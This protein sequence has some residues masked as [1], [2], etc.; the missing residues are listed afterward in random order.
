MGI[1]RALRERR[2]WG[3]LGG[4]IVVS[5]GVSVPLLLRNRSRDASG[6]IPPHGSCRLACGD[7]VDSSCV[8]Y[9]SC[10]RPG[11]IGSPPGSS[12]RAVEPPRVANVLASALCND[13]RFVNQERPRALTCE[14]MVWGGGF[15]ATRRLSCGVAFP[16]LFRNECPGKGR[17]CPRLMSHGREQQKRPSLHPL[18][19][20]QNRQSD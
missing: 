13:R 1:A 19:S 16:D 9:R 15:R 11:G 14:P 2:G 10:R 4:A 5:E 7:Y 12:G 17:G 3:L 18:A 20:T 8:F 6:R